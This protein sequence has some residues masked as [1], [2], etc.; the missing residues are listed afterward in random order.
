VIDR[1]DGQLGLSAY[2][3]DRCFVVAD[4]RH[5]H[6]GGIENGILGIGQGSAT[7]PAIARSVGL[8]VDG[9]NYHLRQLTRRLNVPN[10]TAL[11]ARAYVLGV[12]DARTWPPAV[13]M[14]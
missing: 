7:T 1:S 9:V 10:R 12:L 13:T 11:V 2:L 5:Q 3:R 6:L 4:P 14:D 8:T